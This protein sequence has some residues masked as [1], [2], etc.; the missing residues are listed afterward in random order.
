MNG[1]KK[2]FLSLWKGLPK[3]NETSVELSNLK[4]SD[5]EPVKSALSSE[6]VYFITNRDVQG[7]VVAYFSV[8]LLG[9]AVALIE[10]RFQGSKCVTTVKSSD[11]GIASSMQK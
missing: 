5:L 10:L 11:K 1:C 8:T 3:D 2:K 9:G 7:Q 4:T 6:N